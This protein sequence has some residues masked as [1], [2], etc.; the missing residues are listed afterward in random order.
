MERQTRERALLEEL[1]ADHYKLADRF[2]ETA[3]KITERFDGTARNV[4]RIVNIVVGTPG[5]PGVLKNL[6]ETRDS[7]KEASKALEPIMGAAL[8]AKI[9]SLRRQF[10]E[11]PN[12]ILKAASS[13]EF[14]VRLGAVMVEATKPAIE[15]AQQAASYS[16]SAH[17]HSEVGKAVAAAVNEHL[18]EPIMVVG[19]IGKLEGEVDALKKRV[20]AHEETIE[21][22]KGVISELSSGKVNRVLL[23]LIFVLG[24]GFS[25]F[26]AEV[27]PVITHWLVEQPIPA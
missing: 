26:A 4:E 23:W 13:V 12:H 21:S 27:W 9:E 2:E 5:T 14:Q 17:V 24:W 6:E 20:A 7:I 1:F 3:D 18:A 10:Y 22:Q 19:Y 16:V 15:Q 11:V 8:P 25:V